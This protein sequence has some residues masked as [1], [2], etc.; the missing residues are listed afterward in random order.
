MTLRSYLHLIRRYIV[1]ALVVGALAAV[2]AAAA[3]QFL[4][5]PDYTA[6][7]TLTMRL[8]QD[9]SGPVTEATVTSLTASAP[10]LLRS[11]LVLGP[12][13][14]SLA[15]PMASEVLDRRIKFAAP[16]SSLVL[17][18]MLTDPDAERAEAAL[19]AV[20]DEFERLVADGALS[21]PGGVR[22][23]VADVSISTQES[24]GTALG[25]MGAAIVAAAVGALVAFSYLALR[26]LLDNRVRSPR[27]LE[28]ITDDAVVAHLTGDD[29]DAVSVLARNFSFLAPTTGSRVVALAGLAS[30]DAAAALGTAVVQQLQAQGQAAVAVDLDLAGRP[31]GDGG[32]GVAEFLADPA[33][34]TIAPE[35]NRLHAGGPVPNPVD[36]LT[37]PSLSSLVERL[38]VHDRWVILVTSPLLPTSAGALGLAAADWA[39][40]VV[41]ASTDSKSRV[42]DGLNVL[43]LAG[44]HLS[45]LV[46][47]G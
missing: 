14:Q 27:D 28:S 12:A 37:R 34:S 26:V 38:R 23:E 35:R 25:V 42:R 46:L 21:G 15:P 32:P 11:A 7:A 33:T 24:A 3:S 30:S 2:A 4:N 13:G 17:T 43:E 1:G 19:R 44:V 39:L 20:M 29:V 10:A 8:Q 9:S 6:S 31:F 41:D 18:A 40:L 16:T 47:S 5:S 22:L 36:L 45:G